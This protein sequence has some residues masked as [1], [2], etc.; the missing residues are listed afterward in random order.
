MVTE[1]VGT[2]NADINAVLQRGRFRGQHSSSSQI[3]VLL[4]QI[5]LAELCGSSPLMAQWQNTTKS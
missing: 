1:L 2:D 3:F 4:L 5:L